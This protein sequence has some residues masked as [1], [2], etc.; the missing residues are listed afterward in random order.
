MTIQIVCQFVL[1]ACL[2]VPFPLQY[3]FLASSKVLRDLL[4]LC[5]SMPCNCFDYFVLIL[6]GLV[7]FV[8]GLFFVSSIVLRSAWVCSSHDADHS[9]FITAIRCSD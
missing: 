7:F 8:C 4:L 2:A 9:R 5:F 6:L 1:P 3:V